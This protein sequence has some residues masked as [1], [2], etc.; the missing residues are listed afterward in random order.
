MR[1]MTMQEPRFRTRGKRLEREFGS[2]CL[3]STAPEHLSRNFN[4]GPQLQYIITQSTQF[5]HINGTEIFGLCRLFNRF[6]SYYKT[7][8]LLNI[9]SAKLSNKI[10]PVKNLPFQPIVTFYSLLQKFSQLPKS[11]KKY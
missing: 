1:L 5:T 8:G 4:I 9:H 2:C 3:Q 10:P 11:S 6:S 7:F